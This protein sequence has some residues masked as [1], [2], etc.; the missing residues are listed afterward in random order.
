MANP[1]I[2]LTVHALR[3]RP[4]V[5]VPCLTLQAPVSLNPVGCLTRAAGGAVTAQATDPPD[6]APRWAR[7]WWNVSR[8]P[9]AD[10]TGSRRCLAHNGSAPPSAPLSIHRAAGSPLRNVKAV[11][12]AVGVCGGALR[13]TDMYSCMNAN[14]AS[15]SGRSGIAASI[16]PT[17]RR[18][19]YSTN[20][21]LGSRSAFLGSTRRIS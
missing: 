4:P 14:G 1:V 17:T 2:V 19:R 3:G 20:Q 16:A 18:I 8:K 5:R 12:W 7:L 9:E 10:N 21:R 13:V 11:H 6:C 15:R